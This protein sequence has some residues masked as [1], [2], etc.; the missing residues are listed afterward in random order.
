MFGCPAK[1]A[2]DRV[3]A[4][5]LAD[6]SDGTRAVRQVHAIKAKPFDQADMTVDNEGDVC[7]MAHRTQRVG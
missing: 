2:D 3:G 7:V 4:K 5:C 6:F 1:G